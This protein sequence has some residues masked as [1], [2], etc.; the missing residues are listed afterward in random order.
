[1]YHPS[2]LRSGTANYTNLGREGIPAMHAVCVPLRL[3]LCLC[4]FQLADTAI[5]A[6]FVQRIPGIT[7]CQGAR[8]HP[9]A[10]APRPASFNCERSEQEAAGLIQY[11]RRTR[12]K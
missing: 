5:A 1:M 10:Q 2:Q 8:P 12:C 11:G 7:L 9:S 4:F 6:G 3:L